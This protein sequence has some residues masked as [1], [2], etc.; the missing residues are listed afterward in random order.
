MRIIGGEYKSRSISMPRGVEIRPTQDKVRE[1]LFN[2]LGDITGRRALELFAGSGA[3]GIEAISRGAVSVTFVDNNFRCVQTIKSN[4]ESLGITKSKYSV[5]KGNALTMPE[6]F[7][8]RGQEFGKFDIVF[9]DPP[10]YR[11]MAKKCLINIDSYDIVSP[12]GL[13]IVEH[14]KKDALYAEL[15]RFVFVDERRY[16]D[17]VITIYKRTV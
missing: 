4:L 7:L 8:G 11:G 2:I 1:A 12:V 9:L 5:I 16:G 13:V 14:S 10:Y 6:K 3:F 15:E 17:T